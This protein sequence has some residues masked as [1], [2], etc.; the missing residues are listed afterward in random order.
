MDL[1]PGA[2]NRQ[3]REWLRREARAASAGDRLAAAVPAILRHRAG[4]LPLYSGPRRAQ[5]DR[6]A[7]RQR[8]RAVLRRPVA[9]R[10]SPQPSLRLPPGL[11]RLRRLRAGA[12]R[13]RR[14]S[15]HTRSTRRMRNANRDLS[16]RLLAPRATAEQ[17]RLFSAYQ[18]SRHRDSD[19]AV[20][21]LWRLP[22]H[23]RGHPGA[24]RDRRV[25]RRGRAAGRG[26]ADRPAR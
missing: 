15:R 12:D 6:R 1:R 14:A 22:G 5:A 25:S 7:R 8:R 26:I 3:K 9:R 4:R 2:E 11:P 21:E 16:G 17:F 24:H 18:H 20:D 23:G 19:M 13:R 10:V